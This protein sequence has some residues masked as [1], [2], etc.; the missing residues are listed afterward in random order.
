MKRRDFIT[1]VSSAA[2]AWPLALRAQQRPM[3]VIGFLHSASPGPFARAVDSFVSLVQMS[4]NALIVANDPFFVNRRDQIVALAAQHRMPA[5]YFSREFATAGGLLSYGASL[6]QAARQAD[7]YA[8]K[9][10]RGEKPADLPVMQ[11][12]KFEFIVNLKTAKAT[13]IELPVNLVALAD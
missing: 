12:T 5:M 2:V 11:S 6:V 13:G 8:G 7:I 10:L 4:A 9:I 3:P 1:L